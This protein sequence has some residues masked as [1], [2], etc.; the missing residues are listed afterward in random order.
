MKFMTTTISSEPAQN[1]SQHFRNQKGE[2]LVWKK[3]K[4]AASRKFVLIFLQVDMAIRKLVQTISAILPAILCS[5]RLSPA[6]EN[7][8]FISLGHREIGIAEG[9]CWI[10][11]TKI[12]RRPL[13]SADS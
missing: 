2:N 3:K 4:P 12:L 7:K 13:D 5:K 10:W 1:F 6:N 9:V 11:S 8:M